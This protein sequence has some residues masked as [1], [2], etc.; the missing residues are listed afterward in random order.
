[1]NSLTMRPLMAGR[2]QRA[3]S[4][5]LAPPARLGPLDLWAFIVPAF[6]FITLAVVGQLIVSELVLLAMLPWLWSVRDRLR[7]PRWFIALGA[8]WLLSQVVTDI[9]VGSPFAD[10]ARGWAAIV[11]TLTDL[12]AVLILASTARRARLF[13]L[14]LAAGGLLGYLL[15]PG[16]YAVSDPWKFAFAVPV[17]LTIAAVLSGPAG[18]R[19][20]L[21]TV[22]AFLVFG[23]LNLLFGYRSLGGVSLLTAGYLTL[24]AIASRPK[25]ATI[26]KLRAATGLVVLAVAVV[27][28][29]QVY[30]ITASQGLL[31]ADAQAK[32]LDQSGALGV[33][34][35][36]RSEVLASSQAIL[37]SPILG[38]G[39][40]AKDFRYVDLRNAALSDLGYQIG[41]GPSDLGL[42]PA[43]SYLTQSW[44]WAGL[45]GGAFWVAVTAAALWLLAILY[46][47]RVELAPLLVFSTILLLWNIAFS[48][49]GSS[50]RLLA[51]Y[52]LALCVLGLRNLHRGDADHVLV[53]SDRQPLQPRRAGVDPLGR[54]HAAPRDGRTFPKQAGGRA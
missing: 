5:P 3:E 50:A 31:G 21:L 13:A 6:S 23:A 40:W 53:L 36:G 25:I 8:G 47:H 45:L 33:L 18:A 30:D 24:T 34:V 27:G 14:G 9:V 32:Y 2:L 44:V 22:G 49:Y 48:P 19:L 41:A 43:H 10:F 29:L 4:V 42:I 11:F 26:S 38:H 39:S 16:G 37:D 52:G 28:V 20:R 35:G 46:S 7:L 51:C 12:A 15:V 1:M 17:G 54:S